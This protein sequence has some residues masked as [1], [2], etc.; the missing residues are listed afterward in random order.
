V[1]REHVYLTTQP[2][3][4]PPHPGQLLELLHALDMDER[5]L[6]ATDYPHW[7]F[8]APDRTLAAQT[9]PALRDRIMHANAR[10]LY[11]LPGAP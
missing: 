2:I 6:F 11:R 4:E 7:D 9:P 8:D 10:Q 5:L 1:I 3:E